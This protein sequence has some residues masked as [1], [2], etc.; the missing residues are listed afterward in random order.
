MVS[1]REDDVY[2]KKLKYGW[3]DTRWTAGHDTSLQGSLSGAKNVS[4]MSIPL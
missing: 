3:T 1:F 4:E 2:K